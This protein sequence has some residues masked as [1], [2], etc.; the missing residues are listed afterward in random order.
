[1]VSS[2]IPLVDQKHV[3]ERDLKCLPEPPKKRGK[4]KIK[5]CLMEI[6]ICGKKGRRVKKMVLLDI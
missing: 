2:M 4:E 3:K 1:M 6:E 5:A